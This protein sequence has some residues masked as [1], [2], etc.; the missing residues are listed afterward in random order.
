[1][2]YI[3]ELWFNLSYKMRFLIIGCINTG[4]SYGFYVLFCLILGN[5]SYQTALI[6]SWIFSSIISFT[7]QK[8]FVFK[9][10]GNWFKE[11]F[12]CCL[13]WSLSYFINALCLELCVNI[14]GIN[15]FAAQIL[16][17]GCTA[18]ITYILF[19]K[20]AFKISS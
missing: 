8:Y 18:V 1:M 16:S 3:K 10:K 4:I 5:S 6:L 17:T 11:Y 19:K 2:Q 7:A 12:K 15:I 14:L 13:V 9:S 20:F